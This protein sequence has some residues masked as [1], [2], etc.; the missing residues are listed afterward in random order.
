MDR[1]PNVL[2]VLQENIEKNGVA[3]QVKAKA[4]TW[5]VK[6]EKGV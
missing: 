2:R 5:Y 3:E 6:E 1:D 4:H